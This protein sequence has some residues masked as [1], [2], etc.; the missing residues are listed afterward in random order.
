MANIKPIPQIQPIGINV[1]VYKE[2]TQVWAVAGLL[3][4]ISCNMQ[5]MGVFGINMQGQEVPIPTRTNTTAEQGTDYQTANV[6]I[7]I[8]NVWV[9]KAQF[10]NANF[11]VVVKVK[12]MDSGLVS[13]VDAISFNSNIALCNYVPAPSFCPLVSNI[14]AGT[15]G[16][17]TATITWTSVPASSG[18]EWINNTSGTTPVINGTFEPTNSVTVTGLSAA[19]TYHFWIRTICS[20]GVLSAWTSI[21][22][23][24]HA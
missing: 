12:D 21:T 22:Y 7:G 9:N 10:G 19:T 24:T 20:A 5:Y 18:V 2:G 4:R 3:R 23:T 11:H 8:G 16:T 15:P 1:L 6:L 13:Y 17:T 14:S